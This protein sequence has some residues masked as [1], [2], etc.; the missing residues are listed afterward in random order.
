MLNT[1][2]RCFVYLIYTNTV[3]KIRCI[4]LRLSSRPHFLLLPIFKNHSSVGNRQFLK[5]GNK[6]A[7]D[8]TRLPCCHFYKT[9]YERISNSVKVNSISLFPFTANRLSAFIVNP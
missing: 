9:I 2:K 6:K 8:V 1:V 3:G 7:T 4:V 5:L